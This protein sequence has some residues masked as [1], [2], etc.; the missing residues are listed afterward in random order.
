MTRASYNRQ[1]AEFIIQPEPLF[2]SKTAS[3][4]YKMAA[5]IVLGLAFCTA[6]VSGNPVSGAPVPEDLAIARRAPQALAKRSGSILPAR[7]EGKCYYLADVDP[8]MQTM[9]AICCE[10]SYVPG[11]KVKAQHVHDI[12]NRLADTYDPGCQDKTMSKASFEGSMSTERRKEF[13]GKTESEFYDES[14]L[15]GL[16]GEFH[17]PG[18]LYITLGCGAKFYCNS[19]N[20]DNWCCAA[21]E[22]ADGTLP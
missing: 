12:V 3:T 14:A 17:M 2:R 11:N 19:G 21:M 6:L 5:R 10:K 9:P 20:R 15:S 4:T 8:G 22:K 16:D 1:L 7:S 13:L 18:T